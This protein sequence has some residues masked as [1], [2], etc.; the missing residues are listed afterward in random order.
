M[1][2]SWGSSRPAPVR[3]QTKQR[4]NRRWIKAASQET[5]TDTQHLLLGERADRDGSR[6]LVLLMDNKADRL[7]GSTMTD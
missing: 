1:P 7:T 3:G 4:D 6:S 5:A 2:S